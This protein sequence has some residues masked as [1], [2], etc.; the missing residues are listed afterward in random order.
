MGEITGALVGIAL[1]LTAVFI[2]MAFFSGSVGVIYRQFSV[3]IASAMLLSVLVAVILT[4]ALCA[5]ILKPSHGGGVARFLGWFN[6][7]F[8]S[9]TNGYVATARYTIGR[10]L[11]A[12][13][14]FVLLL[15]GA[16]W[17]YGKL[18][19]SFL[20]EEDQGV[21]MT[22][23]TLPPGA[24]AARTDAVIELVRDYYLPDA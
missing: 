15:G 23:I 18:P 9:T 5:T 7:G 2:P 17:L 10:P 4:P 14:I 22:Q 8:T 19:T 24:N 21:L 13:M 1:V 11:R 3:T 20:P 6:R 12:L 16:Y